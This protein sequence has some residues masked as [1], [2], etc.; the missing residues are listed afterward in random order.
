MQERHKGGK[1]SSL[2]GAIVSGKEKSFIKMALEVC[3]N[4]KYGL[5]WKGLQERNT[6]A[7]WGYCQ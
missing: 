6:L 2:F 4:L 3:I 7:Y 5:G 1:H